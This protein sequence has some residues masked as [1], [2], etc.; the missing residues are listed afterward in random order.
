MPPGRTMSGPVERGG[1]ERLGLSAE[2]RLAAAE[3]ARG[4]FVRATVSVRAAAGCGP[5]K[6]EWG[7]PVTGG[8]RPPGAVDPCGWFFGRIAGVGRWAVLAP[9]NP[10]S[11]VAIVGTT[12]IVRGQVLP[13][14]MYQV[15][16]DV[17]LDLGPEAARLRAVGP[18]IRLV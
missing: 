6:A 15:V 17:F 16:V 11:I 8:I 4:E 12:P 5:R 1:E 7:E 9:E 13:P 10:I 2:V 3:V 14:G 18:E